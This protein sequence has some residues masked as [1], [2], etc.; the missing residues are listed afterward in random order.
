V[1]PPPEARGRGPQ[2]PRGPGHKGARELP[3]RPAHH[4]ST[5]LKVV[6]I[7]QLAGRINRFFPPT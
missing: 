1:N 5:P 6:C 7:L 4:E 3:A 2:A